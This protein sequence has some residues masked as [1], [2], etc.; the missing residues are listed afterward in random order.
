MKFMMLF[1]AYSMTFL[2]YFSRNRF[3][4]DSH[5]FLKYW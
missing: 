2:A 4:D 3:Q 5:P 1:V